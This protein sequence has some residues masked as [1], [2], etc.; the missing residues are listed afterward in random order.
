MTIRFDW[1]T[2]ALIA[3]CHALWALSGTALWL[4][5]PWLAWPLLTISMVL[6]SSLQ[7]EVA[8]GHP[9]KNRIASAALVLPALGLWI[10]FLRFRDLHL[11]HHRDSRLTDPYDDPETNYLDPAAYR[12]LPRP[13]RRILDFNNTLLGRMAIGPAIGLAHF[14]RKD[15]LAVAAGDRRAAL[16]W[17]LHLPAL[18]PVAAFVL[19]APVPAAAYVAATYAAL[20][21]LKIRTFLE[22]RAHETPGGRTALIEDRGPLAFLFLNNNLHIVH[23]THP[24]APWHRL[25]ALHAE[26]PESYLARNHGYRYGGYAEIFRR[27]FLKAKDPVPHPL[28]SRRDGRGKTSA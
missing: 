19:A 23:H 6:H 3:G 10:P 24:T 26:D 16:G 7:H 21:I 15:A 13:V 12:R 2:L 11:A 14:I 5:A 20:S 1:R 28:W 17:L 9:F 25:P 22:H 4:A 8:H 18:A 27:H